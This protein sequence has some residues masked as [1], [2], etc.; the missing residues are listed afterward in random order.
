[1][2]QDLMNARVLTNLGVKMYVNWQEACNPIASWP[3]QSVHAFVNVFFLCHLGLTY[4]TRWESLLTRIGAL[5][6]RHTVI[7]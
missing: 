4:E 5:L 1:M 3:H 2:N 7:Q 6:G